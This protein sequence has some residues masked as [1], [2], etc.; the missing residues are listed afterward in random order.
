M[1]RR[2]IVIASMMHETNTFS[3]IPTPLPS[4][5]PL[6]DEAAIAEFEH[7]NT[8]L[9]GFLDAHA[10]S[11]P[12]NRIHQQQ[13]EIVRP[14]ECTEAPDTEYADPAAQTEDPLTAPAVGEDAA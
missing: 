3:P 4:F 8:Q 6:S 10:E 7:T 9:G 11:H 14:R 13:H 5:R 1:P 12:R 2:K